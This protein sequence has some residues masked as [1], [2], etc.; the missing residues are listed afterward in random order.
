M[1]TKSMLLYIDQG[2][3]ERVKEAA[4]KQRLSLNDFV[5]LVLEDY[6]KGESRDIPKRQGRKRVASAKV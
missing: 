6:L 5:N 4:R 3:H 1:R 2:I